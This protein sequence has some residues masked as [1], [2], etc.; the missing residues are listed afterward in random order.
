LPFRYRQATD[1]TTDTCANTCRPRCD[2]AVC[3]DDGCGGVCGICA[4]DRQCVAGACVPLPPR[5]DAGIAAPWDPVWEQASSN[6]YWLEYTVS[7]GNVTSVWLEVLDG[8]T[9]SL[10][11]ERRG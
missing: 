7:R 1:P 10:G 6:N 8:G 9:A 2:D 3:G 11:V 5:C 4:L